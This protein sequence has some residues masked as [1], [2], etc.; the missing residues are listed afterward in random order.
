M[1][2]KIFKKRIPIFFLKKN[3]FTFDFWK[4]NLKIS[5]NNI[6]SVKVATILWYIQMTFPKNSKLLFSWNW[7]HFGALGLKTLKECTF[8]AKCATII[9]WPSYNIIF[10]IK[11]VFPFQ[12]TFWMV[13]NY[14]DTFCLNLSNPPLIIIIIINLVYCLIA[15]IETFPMIPKLFN[16][17]ALKP[18]FQKN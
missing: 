1:L 7:R 13:K 15:H 6:I 2:E 12:I 17:D 16:L 8:C 3:C 5:I 11:N 18:H 9:L 10:S 14:F 4:I